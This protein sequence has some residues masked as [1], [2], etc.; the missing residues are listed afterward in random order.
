MHR[1]TL[2]YG[3][4]DP[5]VLECRDDASMVAFDTPRGVTGDEARRMTADAL[6]ASIHAPPLVAH[7]VPGDRVVV[8]L[9]G[10]V[11]QLEHVAEAVVGCLVA[12]GVDA[13]DVTLLQAPRLGAD[14]G[15]FARVSPAMIAGAEMFDPVL[16]DATSYLAADE[17]GRPLYLARPLVDADVVVAVGEWSW[18]AA[19]GGRAI[20]GELWPT[21]ARASCR[22]DLLLSLAR[23]GR[24]ALADWK[25]GLHDVLWQLGVCASLR[26]VRGAHGTLHAACF[27]LPDEASQRSRAAA[28]GWS[29]SIAADAGLAIASL[30]DP[31]A[32]FGAITAAVAAGARATRPG[33][34]VCVASRLSEK[35][36]IIFERWRQ[37]APLEGLVHE[38]ISSG[39]NTLLADALQTRLFARALDDRRLVLLSDLDEST[40]EDLEFGHAATPDVVERLAHRAESLV[41][42]PEADRCFPR[43]A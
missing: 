3:A 35:P 13:G 22:R 34:T 31:T 7:V 14:A 32:D 25:S 37:G 6:A 39:D 5:L 17:S 38:A 36:G 23:R 11:P 4:A 9:A 29:P 12:A 1:I 20:E 21:F 15:G 43:Q 24:G 40:V 16:D 19:L 18:N 2:D 8:A 10:D 27:G 28:A 33:G 42:L 30:S 41:V 26:L